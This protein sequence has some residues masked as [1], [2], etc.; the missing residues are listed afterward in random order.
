M[1]GRVDSAERALGRISVQPSATATAVEIEAW[2]ETG[3]TGEL[4][5]P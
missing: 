5:L 1:N 3:F 2:V 4:V